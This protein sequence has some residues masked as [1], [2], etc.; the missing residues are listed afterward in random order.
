MNKIIHKSK[1]DCKKFFKSVENRPFPIHVFIRPY[2][3]YGLFNSTDVG[4]VTKKYL[5]FLN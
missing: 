1:E 5:M 3:Y 2:F 4:F